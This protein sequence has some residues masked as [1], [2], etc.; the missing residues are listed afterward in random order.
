MRLLRQ[1]TTAVEFLHELDIPH[2]DIKPPNV[3]VTDEEDFVL[4]DYGLAE[5]REVHAGT[6]PFFAPE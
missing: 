2:R 5:S 4:G 6:T 1:L 3:F